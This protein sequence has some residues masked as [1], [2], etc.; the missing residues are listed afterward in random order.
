MYFSYAAQVSL[1]SAFIP[2]FFSWDAS[3]AVLSF[4]AHSLCCR[5][6]LVASHVQA[7]QAAGRCGASPCRW[8][9][10]RQLLLLCP[11][12]CKAA[13]RALIGVDKRSKSLSALAGNVG[14]GG[15]E[16]RM[17]LSLFSRA[18]VSTAEELQA[19]PPLIQLWRAM[20]PCHCCFVPPFAPGKIS[21]VS[22]DECLQTVHSAA[23]DVSL[24]L[25]WS[26]LEI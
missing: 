10:R 11:S 5:S 17:R 6:R 20:L 23:G 21:S 3:Q 15:D 9:R 12:S 22:S 14:A 1:I 24:S 26:K 16:V 7:L 8:G 2:L 25:A 18:A 4:P 13:M 19:P